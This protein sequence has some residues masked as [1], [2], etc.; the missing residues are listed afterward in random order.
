[1]EEVLEAVIL[2]GGTN[3]DIEYAIMDNILIDRDE[4]EVQPA[5]YLNHLEVLKNFRFHQEDLPRLRNVLL[6]PA[7]VVTDAGDRCDG[8]KALLI[9]LKRLSYPVRL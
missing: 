9:L 2:G 6:I 4:M 1:M 7:V 8:F 5:F 3:E